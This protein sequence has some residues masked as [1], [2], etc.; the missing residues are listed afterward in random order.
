MLGAEVFKYFVR[1]FLIM[2]GSP[3]K[4]IQR[5]SEIVTDA[6]NALASLLRKTPNVKNR[7]VNSCDEFAESIRHGTQFIK[8]GTRFRGSRNK[9]IRQIKNELKSPD[10]EIDVVEFLSTIYDIKG[11]IERINDMLATLGDD[12][13]EIRQ[14]YNQRCRPQLEELLRELEENS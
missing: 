14:L 11:S 10:I 9:Y 6:E 2:A 8:T 12:M 4:D 13:S 5:V 3:K 1:V 7:F